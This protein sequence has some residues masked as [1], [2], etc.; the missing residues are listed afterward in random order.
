[1]APV[2][3]SGVDGNRGGVVINKFAIE[4]RVREWGL[5]DD[6]VE[7][8]YVLG[9]I[10]WGI[11]TEA[12]LETTWALKGGTG[13]KKCFVET[14]RFSE[15]LDFTVL[16]GGP[17][18]PADILP[19]LGHVLVRVG[20]ESGINFNTRPPKLESRA[21]DQFTQGRIYYT[22]PRQARE[23]AS[24]KLDI[25]ASEVMA[26]ATVLRP[27]SHPYPDSLPAPATVRCYSLIEIFAEKIRAMGERG[28]PRDLYD[29]I[30][31]FRQDDLQDKAGLVRDILIAKCITKGVTV[32]TFATLAQAATR[33]ELESEWENMLGHQLPEL[34]PLAAFWDELPRF[35]AWLEGTVPEE[36][37]PLEATPAGQDEDETWAPP[38]MV[39]VWGAGVPLET[40]RFAAAN[41]LCVELGYQGSRRLI[42]PYSLRRTR[43][44]GLLL[45]ARKADTH[46]HRSYRVDKIES[47]RATRIPFFPAYRIE[48][49]P[50]GAIGT[51]F[52]PRPVHNRSSGLSRRPEKH[53]LI[54]VIACPYCQKRFERRQEGNTKMNKHNAKWGGTCP[55]SSGH[56]HLVNVRY[57]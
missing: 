46:E 2:G 53:G 23:V 9:W 12:T 26:A 47:V 56:G 37:L 7:K 32:P 1:M 18:N 34:P 6:V 45:H 4:E 35:F 8:D 15:D 30:Y 14:Y 16:P 19:L 24:I 3:E 31:L 44:G 50:P 36:V 48:F 10:L 11:G 33:G 52:L 5:R 13:L 54:Y 38:A 42:E 20:E 21:A 27:V 55:G 39:S 49:T 17:I 29:I 28:R 41:H 43:V 25:S 40:I 57:R 22:G 51:P